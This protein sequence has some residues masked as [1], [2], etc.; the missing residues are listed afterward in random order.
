VV[1]EILN[2]FSLDCKTVPI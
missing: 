1:P 2:W